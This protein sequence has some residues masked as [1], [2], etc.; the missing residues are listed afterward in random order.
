MQNQSRRKLLL[1][2]GIFVLLAVL[3][4]IGLGSSSTKKPTANSGETTIVTD[5]TSGQT[6]ITQK[7]KAPERGD[8]SST[9]T[10]L[11]LGFG[12]LVNQ[13]VSNSQL[14]V[15]EYE[16]HKY[17]PLSTGSPQI[18]LATADTQPIGPEDSNDPAGRWSIKSHIVVN[19][20]DTYQIQFFYTGISNVQLHL[21][22][23][24]GSTQLFD[25]GDLDSTVLSQETSE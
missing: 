22:D 8:G 4:F 25:S 23:K 15:L 17:P 9:N 6:V 14:S 24:T 5:P 2:G 7:G 18:S 19:D 11:F 21:Y 20:K 10:P 13:G 12:A 1:F 3:F 16:L